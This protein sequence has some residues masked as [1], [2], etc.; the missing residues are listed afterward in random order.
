LNQIGGVM[1]SVLASSVVDRVFD[2]RSDQ[3]K[4][5]K[6]GIRSLIIHV[7]SFQ[8]FFLMN[9]Y[10]RIASYAYTNPVQHQDG[11]IYVKS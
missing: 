1:V 5:Y 11:T 8:A 6:I 2:S 3:M 10:Y 4:D 9:Q 7:I